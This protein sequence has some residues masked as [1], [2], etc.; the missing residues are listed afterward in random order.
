MP[1]PSRSFYSF[2]RVAC[3]T[4]YSTKQVTS[5]SHV[6]APAQPHGTV[7]FPECSVS[8]GTYGNAASPRP[9]NA[10]YYVYVLCVT[11]EQTR[12]MVTGTTTGA[13]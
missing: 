9:A 5:H 7:G 11:Q 2:A 3:C 4:T 8:H 13:C 12:A 6:V 10:F 1:D